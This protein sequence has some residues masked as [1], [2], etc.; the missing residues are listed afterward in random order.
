MTQTEAFYENVKLSRI[1]WTALLLPHLVSVED[2][3]DAAVADA[4]LPGDDAGANAGG[5]HLDDLEADVV[6]QRPPID[7]HPA[8]L[9]DAPLAC[10][11]GIS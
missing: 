9:V 7:E 1:F 10:E 8:Q 5:G 11:E 2:L 6:G 4:Q 3:A